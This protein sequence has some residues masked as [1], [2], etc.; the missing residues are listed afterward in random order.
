MEKQGIRDGLKKV[1]RFIEVNPDHRIDEYICV[2]ELS[3]YLET[4]KDFR[5]A[6]PPLETRVVR[7]RMTED[8]SMKNCHERKPQ[9]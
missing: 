6:T 8:G 3:G 2:Q 1:W 4:G 9:A 5:P 7:M